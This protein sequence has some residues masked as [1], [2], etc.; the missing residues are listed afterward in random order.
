MEGGT[1][2][3][4]GLA[5]SFDW[6][7]QG[8]AVNHICSVKNFECVLLL[9]QKQPRRVTM[10][11]NAKKVVEFTQISHGKFGGEGGNNG[12]E[13]SGGVCCEDNVVNIQN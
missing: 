6:R 8:I 11:I 7:G 5:A 3:E 13:E 4:R 10:R 2:M 1:I 9:R 12:M